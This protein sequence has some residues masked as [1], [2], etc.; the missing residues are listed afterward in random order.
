MTWAGHAPRYHGAK[1]AVDRCGCRWWRET[2][3]PAHRC[4]AHRVADAWG[5]LLHAVIA[6]ALWYGPRW[7]TLDRLR[8]VGGAI[9]LTA[10]L[11]GVFATVF[12]WSLLAEGFA[13]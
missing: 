6:A 9:Y 7:L 12:A 5:D 4:H 10:M 8:V 3:A 1:L 11:A 2:G 13:P